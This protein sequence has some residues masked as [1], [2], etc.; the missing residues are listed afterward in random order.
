MAPTYLVSKPVWPIP[1]KQMAVRTTV[2]FESIG[3][4]KMLML[5]STLY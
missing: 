2:T 3:T 4:F 5:A 1:Y